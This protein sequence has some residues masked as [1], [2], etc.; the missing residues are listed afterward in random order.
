MIILSSF[1]LLLLLWPLLN[2]NWD[3]VFLHL[4][5]LLLL[6]FVIE[7]GELD[8]ENFPLSNTCI[9]I[10]EIRETSSVLRRNTL[11]NKNCRL[12]SSE[13]KTPE[14]AIITT[15]AKRPSSVQKLMKSKFSC[16]CEA[17][18]KPKAEE[19]KREKRRK[20]ISQLSLRVRLEWLDQICEQNGNQLWFGT[21]L[22]SWWMNRSARCRWGLFYFDEK[23]SLPERFFNHL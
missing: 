13:E 8:W 1:L 4:F 15:S 17:S 2:L 20:S 14:T 6:R 16:S 11:M 19:P 23:K 5:L 7:K 18:P 21:E 22:K 12:L 9:S 10:G 3:A